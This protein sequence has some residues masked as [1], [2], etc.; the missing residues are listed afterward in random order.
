MIPQSLDHATYSYSGNRAD[1]QLRR[2]KQGMVLS[3][4]NSFHANLVERLGEEL[5]SEEGLPAAHRQVT[6]LSL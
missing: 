2:P 6:R 5:F 4:V 3:F 1:R